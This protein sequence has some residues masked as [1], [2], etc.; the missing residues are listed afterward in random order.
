MGGQTSKYG[1]EGLT[2][3]GAFE[4]AMQS[5]ASRHA[6]VTMGGGH[7]RNYFGGRPVDTEPARSLREYEASISAKTKEDVVRRL[8]R[9]LKRAGIEVDPEGDL[10]AITHALVEQIP[11]P[12]NGKTFAS[13]AKSQ[14]KVCSVIADVLND[15]F[16]PGVTK[17]SEKFIDTS[18]GP[19]EMC[20]AVGEWAHSFA[21]GV[22]VEFLAVHASVKNSLRAIQILDEVMAK[23]YGTI[24]KEVDKT[25]NS[26]LSRSVEPLNTLYIRA[27]NE[28]RRQEEL[29]KNILNVQL[30]PAAKELEIAMRDESEQN[31]LIK[32][33]GLAPGTSEFGD[34]LAMAISGLGTAAS[35]AQRVHKALKL[36]GASVTQ[37][38]ESSEFAEFRRQ[39]DSK[40]ENNEIKFEELAKFIESV[41]VLASA[42][43]HRKE[44]RFRAALEDAG[45]T[46]GRPALKR[47]TPSRGLTAA[48]K[49]RA[50]PTLKRGGKEFDSDSGDDENISSV[51]KRAKRQRREK[52]IILHD[53]AKRMSRNYDDM[54]SAVKTLGPK[55]GKEIPLSARMDILRDALLRLSDLRKSAVRLELSLVGYYLDADA[56]MLKENFINAVRF[57][58]SACTAIMGLEIYRAQSS[59]FA[60]L[61]AAIDGIEKTV[62]FFADV[63]TKKY[64]RYGVGG[65]AEGEAA[66]AVG[67][68]L[69]DEDLLPNISRNEISLTEAVNEFAYFYYVAK[70]RINLDQTAAEIDSYSENYVE[71]LGN[72][73]ASRIYILEKERADILQRF[74][75][76]ERTAANPHGREF[77]TDTALAQPKAAADKMQ[78]TMHWIREEYATKIRFYKALQAIDLYMKAFTAGVIK[79]PD[80]V[81]EIKK[82]LD[83]TQANARWFNEQTGD[84][85]WKAFECMGSVA[86]N[87]TLHPPRDGVGFKASNKNIKSKTTSAEVG[88]EHHYYEKLS[89]CTGDGDAFGIKG[90]EKTGTDLS[91]LASHVGVPIIGADI[92]EKEKLGN[93]AKKH[94]SEAMDHFQALKNIVNAFA[95]IGDNFGGRELRTQVFMSPTQIYKTLIEYLKVSAL[96]INS[97]KTIPYV[98]K[99]TRMPAALRTPNPLQRV[100]RAAAGTPVVPPY[101][102]F[103][104]TLGAPGGTNFDGNFLVEDRF[105]ALAIKSMAAKLLTTLGVYDM[106]ERTTPIYDLTPTRMIVGGGG[107]ESNV[108]VIEGAAELYFRLPRLAEFYY[109]LKWDGEQGDTY[110]IAMLPELEGIF[111][112]I[113]RLIFLKDQV[114]KTIEYSDNDMRIMIREINAIYNNFREKHDISQV[115]QEILL[116]FVVEINRRYGVI[117]NTD[118]KKYWSM[119]NMARKGD[120]VALNNTNYA[121]LPDEDSTSVARRAPSDQYAVSQTQY[122]SS[123]NAIDPLTGN[124]RNPYAGVKRRNAELP[125]S[126]WNTSPNDNRKMLREFRKLVEDKIKAVPRKN[127]R[128]VSYSLLI[129]QAQSEIKRATSTDKKLDFAFKLIKGTTITNTDALKGYMFHENVILGLNALSAVESLLR[130]FNEKISC[131]NPQHIEN[132]I[133]DRIYARFLKVTGAR[134]ADNID[135]N[136]G[137]GAC[138]G[139]LGNTREHYNDAALQHLFD[140]QLDASSFITGFILNS[141]QYNKYKRYLTL[142]TEDHCNRAGLGVFGHDHSNFRIMISV[143]I[144]HLRNGVDED[145][146]GDMVDGKNDA[147]NYQEFLLPCPPSFYNGTVDPK[148]GDEMKNPSSVGAGVGNNMTTGPP[149]RWSQPRIEFLRALRIYARFAVNYKL[150]MYDY[151]ENVFA[152]VGS[153]PV[154]QS[155]Q[156]LVD[157]KFI[158]GS[159]EKLDGSIQIGFSKLR[160]VSES[161]LNDVK[162]Y[163]DKL[164]PYIPKDVLDQF[165]NAASPGSVGW[166]EANLVDKYFKGSFDGNSEQRKEKAKNTLDGI[167]RRAADVL[168]QLGRKTH[169]TTLGFRDPVQIGAFAAFQNVTNDP[170]WL[171]DSTRRESFGQALSALIFY[172]SSYSATP[173]QRGIGIMDTLKLW[174]PG[175][176]AGAPSVTRKPNQ[177][178]APDNGEPQFLTGNAGEHYGTMGTL[179]GTES[180]H[181]A[182]SYLVTSVNNREASRLLVYKSNEQTEYRSLLFSFNQ[183]MA[184]YLSTVSYSES[185][186]RFYTNLI[187]TFINGAWA[188]SVDTPAGNTWPDLLDAS[189]PATARIGARGDPKSTAILFQSLAYVM[190]RVKSDTMSPSLNLPKHLVATLSEVPL[191]AKESYRAN[192][193]GYIKLFGFLHEKCIFIKQL[194]ESNCIDMGRPTQLLYYDGAQAILANVPVTLDADAGW[195]IF[196]GNPGITPDAIKE[197]HPTDALEGIENLSG[198]RDSPAMK[199]RLGP[200]VDQ[201]LYAANTMRNAASEVLKELGDSPVYFETQEGSIESY[202]VSYGKSPLMP[203]SLTAW[204]LNNLDKAQSSA[205]QTREGA[206]SNDTNLYPSHTL[207]SPAFKME[208]GVRQLLARSNPVGYDQIPSVKTSL[209]EYNAASLPN[210]VID[211][212]K[213]LEYVNSVMSLLRFAADSRNYKPMIAS[214]NFLF[215][216]ENLLGD[217]NDGK[218][219][220]A[221]ENH[222]KSTVVWPLFGQSSISNND[223]I[224]VVEGS[225]QEDAVAK[226]VRRVN[227]DTKNAT[228]EDQCVYNLIDMNIIPINVHALMRDIP[229]ANLYNYEFTFEQM[230]ASMF[231][232]QTSKFNGTWIDGGLADQ[233]TKNTRQMFL[234]FLNNPYIEVTNDMYGDGGNA[235][236]HRIFRGDNNLGMGRPKFLSDQ[237][238]N[239]ALFGSIYRTDGDGRDNYDEAGPGVGAGHFRGSHVNIINTLKDSLKVIEGFLADNSQKF[240]DMFDRGYEKSDLE[241]I[242]NSGGVCVNQL[243]GN[244]VRDPM[245]RRVVVEGQGKIALTP[246]KQEIER[247]IKERLMEHDLD[248]LITL[249]RSLVNGYPNCLDGV[250]FDVLY[251]GF[252]YS[253]YPTLMLALTDIIKTLQNDKKYSEGDPSVARLLRSVN[254]TIDL[255]REIGAINDL[256]EFVDALTPGGARDGLH[257]QLVSVRRSL[258]PQ[259]QELVYGRVPTVKAYALETGRLTADDEGLDETSPSLTYLGL[260][261]NRESPA[262]VVKHVSVGTMRNKIRLEAIGKLR[263]DTYFVRK[264]FFITNIARVLRLKLNRELTQSRSVLPT[265]H[266]SVT[267]GIT[268]YDLDPFAPNESFASRI[269]DGYDY[270]NVEDG[271]VPTDNDESDTRRG[272]TRFADE[273]REI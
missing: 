252:K 30:A 220:V 41:E 161:I 254:A 171:E 246:K 67:G 249:I 51:V 118:M 165:E 270:E 141:D 49:R 128:K 144:N 225:G 31:A 271:R 58:S 25:K 134:G 23:A 209:D 135:P 16:T 93:K 91:D 126:D 223:I 237:L 255:C 207:G 177:A 15:E 145:T 152:L 52:K 221:T 94:I 272:M 99:N 163:I 240:V 233:H 244:V 107:G 261:E 150:I 119:V 125:V 117:K 143:A 193:P 139:M 8:A 112:E 84:S 124:A 89:A 219:L 147:N 64:G 13:E 43:S 34:S 167:A 48:L 114:G 215:S 153:M 239:K 122:D 73:V 253:T 175:I 22:N 170:T 256:G 189:A 268:E 164:R 183:L 71:L 154:G 82:M 186:P 187:N 111:S 146:V 1:G 214:T 148:V 60:R 104:G 229:L 168:K 115:C 108:E 113:I 192:L 24:T 197:L 116:A 173:N 267:P 184:Q 29:I 127:F 83:G 200:I 4:L 59:D 78:L 97:E 28:R 27:Q 61:K 80:A 3:C 232:E 202:K 9:A 236:T 68:R 265:S 17:A 156:R 103:F 106:F 190:Q 33:L 20:R 208:Y 228:R 32:R 40:L 178:Y 35:I 10:D 75:D 39:V 81:R 182:A 69:D 102:V 250:L 199:T 87:G 110:K 7:D 100:T 251:K 101:Q 258:E 206:F 66:A 63:F 12:K 157:V 2:N 142:E 55:L 227:G 235:F 259:V 245:T 133:M 38:L 14:N 226:I 123:L 129:R 203:L 172:D 65:E 131:M 90:S 266:M 109:M 243:A 36:V 42:F 149:M 19:V 21:A 54:L 213:N 241:K 201:I 234:R 196:V 179:I 210:E 176:A 198:P 238:F 98:E 181:S 18:I 205:V 76:Q 26:K 264:L 212:K 224:A 85:I 6:G 77:G 222:T 247:G 269:G 45:K 195:K 132:E 44:S 57:I 105:F 62:D 121:I 263:F 95:R 158:P 70:V 262:S 204:F 218:G 96:S 230:A 162:I 130:S 79:D 185:G 260:R 88:L 72:A 216:T 138:S 191:H 11:N 174:Q 273:M 160:D 47:T 151:V 5:I 120:Q 242:I 169:V 166:L 248:E 257:A 180:N 136:D 217:G 188:K 50:A 159:N 74:G 231:G 56:R 155:G 137:C 140:T 46:G 86:E 92:I 194:M 37:Y 53:F 211:E